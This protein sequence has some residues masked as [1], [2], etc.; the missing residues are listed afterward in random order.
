MK[1]L[2]ALTAAFIIAS[3][4]QEA[5]STNESGATASSSVSSQSN[6]SLSPA[7]RGQRLFAQET[8]ATCHTVKEGD[9]NRIGPNLYDVV[10]REAGQVEGFAYTKAVTE[11]GITWT[12]ENL[13]A[14]LE[15]P[16]GFMRGNRMAYVGQRDA[17]KRAALIAYL[18]TLTPT[19]D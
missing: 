4:S 9:V 8:C 12:E 3:C 16:Q 11:S 19:A 15:N 18:K 5:S 2:I 1:R 6:E 17:E 13:D 10:G 14:F 7:E